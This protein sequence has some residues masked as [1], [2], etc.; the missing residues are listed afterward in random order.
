M[1]SSVIPASGWAQSYLVI[2]FSCTVATA[3][4]AAYVNFGFLNIYLEINRV[5]LFS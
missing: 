5:F 3:K 4:Q 2:A 1:Q